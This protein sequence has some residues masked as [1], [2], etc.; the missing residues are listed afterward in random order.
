MPVSAWTRHLAAYRA[1]HPHTSLKECMIKA[2]ESYDKAF[3][4]ANKMYTT[5]GYRVILS[6]RKA[7][8]EAVMEHGKDYKPI[9]WEDVH[10]VTDVQDVLPA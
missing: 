3:R 4:G 9:I 10:T 1:V 5:L 7:R 2:S 8:I 6:D